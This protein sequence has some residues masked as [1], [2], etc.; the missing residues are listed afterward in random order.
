LNGLFGSALATLLLFLVIYIGNRQMPEIMLFTD[1]GTIFLLVVL[2]FIMGMILSGITT[3]M[4][5]N[6]YLGLERDKLYF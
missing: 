6:K 3:I 4:A 2:I 1:S 5:V